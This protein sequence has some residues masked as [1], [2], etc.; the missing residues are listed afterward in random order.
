M[1]SNG[2]D[3]VGPVEAELLKKDCKKTHQVIEYA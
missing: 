3:S 1:A 2:G